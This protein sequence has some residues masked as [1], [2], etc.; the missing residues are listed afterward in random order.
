MSHQYV[1]IMAG[2]IGSR[3]WPKSRVHYPK[4]FLDILD[5]GRTLIQLTYDRFRKVCPAENIYIVT[6][7][8][9][10]PIVK[11][12]LPDI[13]SEQILEEPLRR[14][15]APCISYVTNKLAARDPDASMVITPSDHFVVDTED[16]ANVIRKGLSFVEENDALLTLGIQPTKPD[17]GYGYIQYN[18]ESN[19]EGIYQVKTFTE[20]PTLDIAKSFLESGD[21]LWN[22]GI[23][24]WRLKS[25][26]KAFSTHLPDIHEAF[27]QGQ[28]V[29]FTEE[30]KD[31]IAH[32]YS[33][34]PNIAIDFGVMEKAENVYVIPSQFGW[35]DLGTWSS[36]YNVYEKD[37]SSN[38]ISGNDIMTYETKNCM[39]MGRDGKLV[40]LQ[41][42]DNYCVIDTEDTLLICDKN[43]EQEI[44]DIA[45]DVKRSKGDQYL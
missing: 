42:L 14:N 5:V 10:T 6:N 4:Q 7:E 33:I 35:S 25:I 34:C 30:E 29:Y 26:Q 39:V 32:A 15:T 24:L 9:Y 22:S 45:N 18:E 13:S 1:A 16:F 11:E 28:D 17:T 23:F 8:E 41:G 19:S 38:A 40:V 43:K 2:G 37:G 44:K 3:F 21:F 12:Q 20:K 27:S 36:L 31:F